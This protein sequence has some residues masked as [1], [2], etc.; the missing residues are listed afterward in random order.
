MKTHLTI[1]YLV[2]LGGTSFQA[3]A[4]IS[5][6]DD[7][8]PPPEKRQLPTRMRSAMSEHPRIAVGRTNADLLGTDNRALQAA[9]DYIAALDGGTVEI[10]PGEYLMRDSLHLRPHVTIH[11]T[12]GKTILR[13]ADGVESLLATDGDFGEEQITV[14]DPKGFEVG[15]GVAI[16]SRRVGGFHVTVARIIG[17]NGSNLGAGPPAQR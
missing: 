15:C 10:G 4:A 14:A 7:W 8:S 16:W 6:K 1:A 17:R 12:A 5:P 13:K 2:L 9:V 11:G 3:I